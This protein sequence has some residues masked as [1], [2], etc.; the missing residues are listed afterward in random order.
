MARFRSPTG[1][2]TTAGDTLAVAELVLVANDEQLVSALVEDEQLVRESVAKMQSGF[3]KV[4]SSSA[5]MGSRVG[6]SRRAF[7]L[8]GQAANLAGLDML[9]YSSGIG[10]VVV[11]L[12]ALV[13]AT[14]AAT[15]AITAFSGSLKVA[16]A[17]L[18]PLKVAVAAVATFFAFFQ[19]GRF[20][21]NKEA[22]AEIDALNAST[23]TL[24]KTTAETN[25]RYAEYKTRL[26]AIHKATAQ[27][28]GVTPLEDIEAL[29]GT[30]ALGV[31]KLIEAEKERLRI[32]AHNKLRDA[33]DAGQKEAIRGINQ[34][35][36]K[37]RAEQKTIDDR[38]IALQMETAV[39]S[40]TID[41]YAI[42]ENLGLRQATIERDRVSELKALNDELSKEQRT[43]ERLIEQAETGAGAAERIR[44]AMLSTSAAKGVNAEVL[45]QLGGMLEIGALSVARTQELL[46]S[47][48]IA[49]GGS[50]AAVGRPSGGLASVASFQSGNI[51][52]GTGVS[53]FESRVEVRD[54]TRNELLKAIRDKIG[55][56][57][58]DKGIGQ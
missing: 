22:Q 8:L 19:V 58:G 5:V 6:E 21:K 29:R 26:D 27:L 56:I 24:N 15:V 2:F 30:G 42:I 43:R 40:G 39:L 31:D 14:Q 46:Q 20:F 35:I 32:E 57:I 41:K 9:L 55:N 23:E 3:D 36:E 34:L 17:I 47:L 52:L 51:G 4:G 44:D 12:S 38:I 13:P 28:R 7:I 50:K 11:G 10:R 53:P 18:T 45:S 48:G 25:A 37:G 54:Q 49:V 1:R 16:L 33:R